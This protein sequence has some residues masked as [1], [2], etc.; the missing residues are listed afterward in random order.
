MWQQ[1]GPEAAVKGVNKKAFYDAKFGKDKWKSF[2]PRLS[3]VTRF[4]AGTTRPVFS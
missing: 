1:Y 3:Q 4:S 2:M